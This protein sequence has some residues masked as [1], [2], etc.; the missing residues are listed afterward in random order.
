MAEKGEIH[1]G[2][3]IP[4]LGEALQL[5][6]PD[7]KIKG[8]KLYLTQ[9]GVARIQ[10]LG[11]TYSGKKSLTSFTLFDQ[12]TRT[13][14]QF[15]VISG[16]RLPRGEVGR[17]SA[18]VLLQAPGASIKEPVTS[19]IVGDK[20]S[21]EHT[22]GVRI[23][24]DN[25]E[26]VDIPIDELTTENPR[27]KTTPT[28][29]KKP[30]ITQQQPSSD[31][32]YPDETSGLGHEENPPGVFPVEA[33][34]PTTEE[35]P[36][37][38]NSG[39][40]D[41]DRTEHP[42]GG[43]S[44]T[45]TEPKNTTE[46]PDY[47]SG[48]NNPNDPTDKSENPPGGLPLHPTEPPVSV[49]PIKPGE[50]PTTSEPPKPV[51]P[52]VE[53]PTPVEPPNPIEPPKPVEPP[54]PIEPPTPVEPP[55]PVEPPK[56][57]EQPPVEP[58]ARGPDVI[59]AIGVSESE[60]RTNEARNLARKHMEENQAP[61][62]LSRMHA[63]SKAAKDNGQN[64]WGRTRAELT[65][66]S[67]W[68]QD[69][70]REGAFK[71]MIGSFHQLGK[72]IFKGNFFRDLYEDYYH[73]Q[74]KKL[75]D[76]AGTSMAG[77]VVVNA[78]VQAEQHIFH[79]AK[80][81]TLAQRLARDR[82]VFAEAL[83]IIEAQKA[84]G[85]LSPE[86]LAARQA[87]RDAINSNADRYISDSE[88]LIHTEAG[89]HLRILDSTDEKDKKI[90]DAIRSRIRTFLTSNP[91]LS[92]EEFLKNLQEYFQSDEF[93]AYAASTASSSTDVND[94][95]YKAD[96][97]KLTEMDYF[98]T[99]MFEAAKAFRSE[100]AQ[101]QHDRSLEEFDA[102]LNDRIEKLQIRLGI[103]KPGARTREDQT[104]MEKIRAKLP[105]AL[106]V[107]EPVV[108]TAVAAATCI[109]F[110]L[111]GTGAKIATKGVAAAALTGAANPLAAPISIAVGS[112]A[113]GSVAGVTEYHR[114][115]SERK[116][117][118]H[119]REIGETF[120]QTGRRQAIL[121]QSLL[122]SLGGESFLRSA[123]DLQKSVLGA[124]YTDPD[125]PTQLALTPA[126]ITEAIRVVADVRARI[127][128]S[129]RKDAP[130]VMISYSSDT[131][132]DKERTNL[133]FA[134]AKAEEAVIAFLTD[135]NNEQTARSITQITGPI[136]RQNILGFLQKATNTQEQMH[137]D[138]ITKAQEVFKSLAKKEAWKKAG[139]TFG[140]SFITGEG[141]HELSDTLAEHTTTVLHPPAGP[142]HI[143]AD[144]T[145]GYQLP[146][147]MTVNS[148]GDLVHIDPTTHQPD[149]V[150]IDDFSSHLDASG[151]ITP[152]G[153]AEAAQHGYTLTVDH[154]EAIEPDTIFSGNT[155]DIV[156]E[157]D[158][159]TVPQELTIIDNPEGGHDLVI[160]AASPIHGT[161]INDI[162]I[163][164]NIDVDAD[165]NI[166]DTDV[167]QDIDESPYLDISDQMQAVDSV[168]QQV[169]DSS[170][171]FI[172]NAGVDHVAHINL[173]EDTHLDAAQNGTY[174]LVHDLPDGS[175]TTVVE[176][177]HF[178]SHGAITNT[179]AVQQGLETYNSTHT[180]FHIHLGTPDT[181]D[182]TLVE[183]IPGADDTFKLNASEWDPQGGFWGYVE[184][185]LH[186]NGVD[187]N[188]PNADINAIKHILR[189]F[190]YN[191]VSDANGDGIPDNVTLINHG[192][193]PIDRSIPF[194]SLYDGG[195]E[196][197]YPGLPSDPLGVDTQF[198]LP[199]SLFSP[200]SMQQIVADTD[201]A[202]RMYK[203]GVPLESMDRL[204]QI[205]WRIGYS[206]MEKDV[207][208]KDDIQF[209][210]DHYG[211]AGEHEVTHTILNQTFTAE[212][213]S[214]SISGAVPQGG[215]NVVSFSAT[216]TTTSPSDPW[217]VVPGI[218][219]PRTPLNKKIKPTTPPTPEPPEPPTPEPPKP[220]EYGYGYGYGYGYEHR[221]SGS[222]PQTPYIP[223]EE[224]RI[225]S[226][227]PALLSAAYNKWNITTEE[228]QRINKLTWIE[229]YDWLQKQVNSH[230][231]D[232]S[233]DQKSANTPPNPEA[234][235]TDSIPLEE[236]AHNL[237]VEIDQPGYDYSG[238]A[239]E[240]DTPPPNN[241]ISS[242]TITHLEMTESELMAFISDESS[243]IDP[244][245]KADAIA[246]A[247]EFLS[248]SDLSEAEQHSG[249]KKAES[250]QLYKDLIEWL[251]TQRIIDLTQNDQSFDADPSRAIMIGAAKQILWEDTE[252]P[253]VI[254][255]ANL[256][257][258]IS[259]H[260]QQAYSLVD[261]SNPD[262][263]Y[264]NLFVLWA[265]FDHIKNIKFK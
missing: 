173:P 34:K 178:D 28:G 21:L 39:I 210:M 58:P 260:F 90:L 212:T 189:G 31:L 129:D 83:N 167:L 202:I 85:Q 64:I 3:E 68:W 174:T 205:L 7:K 100:L 180:D 143:P 95:S 228:Q 128:I 32:P 8:T 107:N 113:A 91:P 214:H 200:E 140:I 237:H 19:R 136:T 108:G 265:A 243:P 121:E 218:P 92:E 25:G 196:I 76:A 124:I 82:V 106:L 12:P 75:L 162:V 175:H 261:P 216:A 172:D 138:T 57:P 142:A 18:V 204:H 146:E 24:N 102:Y 245:Q 118:Q 160:Q 104:R 190:E 156:I 122:E 208:G 80:K 224:D 13:E 60:L 246:K 195:K 248:L 20:I 253:E 53:P 164:H 79:G 199:K 217:T 62:L 81:P 45:P 2:I 1:T 152:E 87:Q 69:V 6:N 191:Y 262:K 54:K 198:E 33:K 249:L 171:H 194:R 119:E 101:A 27:K 188:N 207:P 233:D 170:Q 59:A 219:L 71:H 252:T 48:I 89:E 145:A 40:D 176:G 263:T 86:L 168:N 88:R 94:P 29:T 65:A 150:I 130:A 230:K 251:S 221:G 250:T 234:E 10:A 15:D 256:L 78:V 229:Q 61:S 98:A 35:Q 132:L 93:K 115:Q 127:A 70:R 213:V 42:P 197:N 236:L 206:G 51:E 157:N 49:E 77:E 67:Q 11:G 183:K 161:P 165:G 242:S 148:S 41:E 74:Y 225:K 144:G 26:H 99:S 151:H 30:D 220:P 125:N 131:A 14:N 37:Q 222:N 134:L 43:L 73:Q 186:D 117:H 155:H 187:L 112:A 109:I 147:S 22:W 169:L 149:G 97:S 44:L 238:T 17:D 223:T 50:P 163:S 137:N 227:L 185:T 110:R 139:I 201:E 166:V 193:G 257:Q 36:W 184:R 47:N 179:D 247:Q 241:D 84:N 46:S 154:T 259:N 159:Y 111:A 23:V 103:A 232:N 63:L 9:A 231:E 203:E 55:N 66:I 192:S 52:P 258:R 226:T 38:Y 123:T 255:T 158:H 215:V 235:P 135:P 240:Q 120:D 56:P 141:L 133:D 4:Q 181:H 239:S 116:H 264:A 105:G 72:N 126:N 114:L 244:T 16:K 153:L 5:G 209:L 211:G 182:V 254:Q 96:I 177:I